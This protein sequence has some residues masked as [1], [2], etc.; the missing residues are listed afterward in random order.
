VV[1]LASVPVGEARDYMLPATG[2]TLLTI[3]LILGI[4]VLVDWQL[5][6]RR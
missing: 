6:R 5:N 2:L 3:V 1:A 4:A